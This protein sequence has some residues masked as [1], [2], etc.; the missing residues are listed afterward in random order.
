MQVRSHK[1]NK[2]FF[3]PFH[4][5]V[6]RASALYCCVQ[7]GILTQVG[8]PCS[9]SNTSFFRKVPA[10]VMSGF[11]LQSTQLWVNCYKCVDGSWAVRRRAE[12]Q[13]AIPVQTPSSFPQ[14]MVMIKVCIP[15][16]L[17]AVASLTY[18]QVPGQLGLLPSLDLWMGRDQST[19]ISNDRSFFPR[20]V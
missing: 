20:K 12:V 8:L 16:P 18:A 17:T 13:V 11:L 2:F 5:E 15:I 3:L 4:C 19:L 6:T 7:I 1:R 10:V 9:R 14:V